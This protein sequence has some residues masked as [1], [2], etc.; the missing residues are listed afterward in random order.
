MSEANKG[1]VLRHFEEIFNKRN[2][3]VCDEIMAEDYL[4]HG[5]AAFAR[6]APGRVNGPKAMR[7]TAE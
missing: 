2:L 3:A 5:M 4:E 6:S 1:L 7:G